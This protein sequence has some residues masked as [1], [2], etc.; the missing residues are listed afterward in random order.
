[1]R[2]ATL[3]RVAVLTARIVDLTADNVEEVLDLA[4]RPDQD[5]YV[6]PVAW[7]VA[8]SAYQQVWTPVAVTVEGEIVGFAEWAYDPSD[9]T[10]CLGGLMV[11]ARRQG[12][13]LGR[14]AVTA[15]VEHL[16]RR[17]DCRDIALT[18]HEDNAVARSLYAALGFVD[19]GE[20]DGDE[21]VMV[22]P[23]SVDL[24]AG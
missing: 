23:A 21:M 13:G 17:P 15:L 6:R 19:T 14:A 11:D 10:Y 1:M 8:R 7:Y 5:R 22:L 16:R 9:E 12:R 20:L 3:P 2:R 24:P 18:V 4:T